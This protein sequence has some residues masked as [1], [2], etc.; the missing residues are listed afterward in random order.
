MKNLLGISIVLLTLGMVASAEPL[1]YKCAATIKNNSN[2]SVF[3]LQLNQDKIFLFLGS[4]SEPLMGNRITTHQDSG[5]DQH[6]LYRIESPGENPY[7]TLDLYLETRFLDEHADSAD[8]L[9]SMVQ[10]SSHDE[11]LL[12]YLCVRKLQ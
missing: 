11:V 7:K 4:H 12:N 3:K 9:F 10:K 6:I 2:L 5:A 8:G 1:N